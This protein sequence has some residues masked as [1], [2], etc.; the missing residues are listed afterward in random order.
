[1]GMNATAFAIAEAS[2]EELLSQIEV[3]SARARAL[4]RLLDEYRAANP[5]PKDI[6]KATSSARRARLPEMRAAVKS[7]LE[8]TNTP[9]LTCEIIERLIERGLIDN[10]R[11]NDRDYARATLQRM[12]DLIVSDGLGRWW[13]IQS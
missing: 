13:L 8:E 4:E 1:M 2:H 11:E 10:T 9:M 3:Y 6:T 7:I 12:K 5:P